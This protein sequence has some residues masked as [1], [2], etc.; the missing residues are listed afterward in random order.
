MD[1]ANTPTIYQFSQ[2]TSASSKPPQ[3]SKPIQTLG[4]E[5]HPYFI[6]MI[7]EQS[8]SREGDANPYSHLWE[9]EQTYTLLRIS[10]MF[11][12][13]LR[14]KLFSFSLMEKAKQWYNLTWDRFNDLI[15]TWP[16]PCNS[17]PN[18]PSTFL[19]RTWQGF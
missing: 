6:N 16:R 9:F 2:P 19:L 12:E 1:T 3:S 7:R 8:F 5:L 13:T 4:Y 18:S 14:W 11:D 10:G 17:R 15:I